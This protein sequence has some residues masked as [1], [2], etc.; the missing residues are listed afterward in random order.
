MNFIKKNLGILFVIIFAIVASLPLF[1]PGFFPMH[2]DEQIARLFDLNQA[3]ADGQFPPRIAPNLGFGYGY[4]FFNFY[5]SFAYYVGEIFHLLGFGYILSTKIMLFMGFFLAAFFTYLLVKE[6]FGRTG[7]VVAAAAYTF[8]PYHAVDIYVRGA[9]AEFFAFVFIPLI[10]WS[11]YKLEKTNKE[12]FII[13]VAL[14]AGFLILSHNLVA[15]MSTPFLALWLI[16]LLFKSPARGRFL[17][18][19]ITGFILG[20]GLSAYFWLPSYFEMNYTLVRILTLELAN[21]KLHF[22]CIHQLFNSAWGYGGSI[23][24]CHDGL[25]FE[26][27]KVHLLT[28]V[29]VFMLFCAFWIRKKLE[30]KYM[31]VPFFS[32]ALLLSMFFT[33]RQS[34]F[35]WDMLPPLWYVQFPWR[36]LMFSSFATSILAGSI[37]VFFKNKK[38]QIIIAAVLVFGFV[39]FNLPDF[40][41]QR[42]IQ[43]SDKDYINS[44]KIRWETSSLSYEYVPGKIKTK[45]SKDNTT[46]VDITRNEIKSSP[47]QIVKREFAVNVIKDLPQEKIFSVVSHSGGVFRINTYSFPGWVIYV[48]GQN[49]AYSESR[50]LVLIEVPLPPG[51]YTIR[52]VFKNTPIRTV[53]NLAS[54]ISI[55]GVCLITVL[56]RR[57]IYEK[58]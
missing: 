8:A 17:L 2:D 12:I 35:I 20:F 42:L 56:N 38:T 11:T 41:P 47:Y 19:C 6:F 16:Y 4:P 55:I 37:V 3:L 30:K 53:G 15:L 34:Q 1:H 7:A 36:F 33:V 50:K 51:V 49:I 45:K 14:S 44:Q 21:Y 54:I 43:V 22:V 39:I 18:R 27:G 28:S 46:I 40:N 26:V 58:T 24:D 13:P 10:F 57:Q 48:D 23:P 9:F 29:I 52:A 31:L 25:S 32:V 5:P